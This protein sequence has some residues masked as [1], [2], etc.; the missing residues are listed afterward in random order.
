MLLVTAIITHGTKTYPPRHRWQI[1]P[2]AARH[3]SWPVFTGAR[4]L[5]GPLKRRHQRARIVLIAVKI[6]GPTLYVAGP[7]IQHEPL[8][9]G[10]DY[11]RWA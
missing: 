6:P 9:F 7:F 4:D 11:F 10:T 3:C 8:S 1:M 2:A 5:G